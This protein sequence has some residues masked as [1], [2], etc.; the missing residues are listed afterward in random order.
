LIYVKYLLSTNKLENEIF[1]RI[2]LESF[3]G[4]RNG[5]EC[6]DCNRNVEH[7]P[8]EPEPSNEEL[9]RRLST[10]KIE[11]YSFSQQILLSSPFKKVSFQL[12]LSLLTRT[13]LNLTRK[14]L[15]L[16]LNYEKIFLNQNFLLVQLNYDSK[17]EI[18]T[19]KQ[20]CAMF[21]VGNLPVLFPKCSSLFSREEIF[22]PHSSTHTVH[23][24]KWF[25][26]KF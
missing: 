15:F 5:W 3:L 11:N 4:P 10:H 25:F 1:H 2:L 23:W 13:W 8:F 19:P 20:N 24:L 7:I 14:L 18:S 12:C 16:K 9:M 17:N 22:Q 6:W 26:V 21:Y